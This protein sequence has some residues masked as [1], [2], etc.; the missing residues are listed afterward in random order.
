LKWSFEQLQSRLNRKLGEEE[1]LEFKPRLFTKHHGSSNDVLRGVV[2]LANAQGG[3]LIIGLRQEIDTWE[4]IGTSESQDVVHNWLTN[5]IF[6]YVEPDGLSFTVYTIE[7]IDTGK[8]CI[9]IE[10]NKQGQKSFSIR[11]SGRQS[12]D[13]GKNFYCFPMRIG[14]STRLLDQFSF[15][16]NSIYNFLSGFS[17]ISKSV[18]ISARSPDERRVNLGELTIRIEEI[19]DIHDD[20]LKLKLL[21]ELRIMINNIPHDRSES[22]SESIRKPILGLLSIIK[23]EIEGDSNT[24]RGRVLD[25]LLLIADRAD[26]E[27]INRIKNDFLVYLEQIYEDFKIAK[28]SK[29]INLLQILNDHKPE[30]IEWM[31]RDSIENWPNHDEFVNLYSNIEVGRCLSGDLGRLR[32]L[33]QYLLKGFQDAKGRMDNEKAERFL[34]MY[35]IVRS[36]G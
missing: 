7:S 22:W 21:D 24:W 10:V 32:D 9:G 30:Y 14:D 19:Q 31:I 34:R 6:E 8:R 36:S 18:T 35:E 26:K 33:R 28:D 20:S 13:E 17:E 2:A 1:S 11:Y 23:R 29:I 15:I 12:R 25:F 27:T 16:R 4:I 3:N 5:I